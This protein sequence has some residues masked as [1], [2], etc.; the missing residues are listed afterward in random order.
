MDFIIILGLI[1]ATLTT[2]S[3]LPQLLKVLKTRSTKDISAVMLVLLSSA[4][5]VWLAYGILIGDVPLIIAN[6]FAITQ[7]VI[8]LIFKIIYK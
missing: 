8:I 6:S 3:L 7:A 1:G 4:F 5:I 2:V